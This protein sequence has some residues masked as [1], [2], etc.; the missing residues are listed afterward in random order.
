MSRKPAASCV[1]FQLLGL[2]LNASEAANGR[3]PLRVRLTFR[4][5]VRTGP[6]LYLE[7]ERRTLECCFLGGM[8]SRGRGLGGM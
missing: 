4:N 2:R 7:L 5:G 8:V 3:A 1:C 6:H